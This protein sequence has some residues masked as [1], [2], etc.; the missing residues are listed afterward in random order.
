M[1]E[2]GQAGDLL[3]RLGARVRDANVVVAGANDEIL[4][5]RGLMLLLIRRPAMELSEVRAELERFAATE[6]HLVT[7]G[8]ATGDKWQEEVAPLIDVAERT[9]SY[10]TLPPV[11]TLI[12]AL[13]TGIDLW[14]QEQS[15]SDGDLL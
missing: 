7:I 2:I 14:E 5:L 8:E 1:P 6:G 15:F 3:P 4:A 12:L 13:A 11:T 9:E 10:K